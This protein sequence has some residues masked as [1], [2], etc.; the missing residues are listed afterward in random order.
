LNKYLHFYITQQ[1][2]YSV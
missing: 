2:I 1:V